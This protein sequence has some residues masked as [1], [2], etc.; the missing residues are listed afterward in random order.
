MLYKNLPAI[1]L[2][3]VLFARL[4]LDGIAGLK[5]LSEG[6]ADDCLAVI[7]AHLQFY[8]IVLTGKLKRDSKLP[9]KVHATIYRG[10][11][12]WDYYILK[13]KKFTDLGFHPDKEKHS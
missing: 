11:I 12:V 5:F 7:K 10:L 4:I 9:H 8:S 13:K 3:P 2:V 1:R 6:G